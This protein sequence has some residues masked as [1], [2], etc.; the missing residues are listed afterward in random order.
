MNAVDSGGL[1]AVSF[2]IPEWLLIVVLIVLVALGVMWIAKVW[3][4][5]Q[6]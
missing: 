5:F 6:G 3:A 2:G 1:G 4:M